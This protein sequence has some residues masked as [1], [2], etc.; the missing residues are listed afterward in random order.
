MTVFCL[1]ETQRPADG[2]SMSLAASA[3]FISA[4]QTDAVFC[5]SEFFLFV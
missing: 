1:A 3:C 2:E 4:K 5:F